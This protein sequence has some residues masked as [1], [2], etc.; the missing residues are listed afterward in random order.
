VAAEN[1]LEPQPRGQ[2]GLCMLFASGYRRPKPEKKKTRT[3]NRGQQNLHAC[4][5]YRDFRCAI[6]CM[7]RSARLRTDRTVGAT[8]TVRRRY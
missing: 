8:P 5:T 7:K 4:P 6:V 1:L 3:P 2:A